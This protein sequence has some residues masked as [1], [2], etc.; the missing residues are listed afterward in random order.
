MSPPQRPQTHTP[1]PA[2]GLDLAAPLLLH[3]SLGD[4]I[5]TPE[6]E[7]RLGPAAWACCAAL[8]NALKLSVSPHHTVRRLQ[9][10]RGVRSWAVLKTGVTLSNLIRHSS[11]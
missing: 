8:A 1:L 3:G 10:V 9:G 7:S 2:P 11:T 6:D 5:G 4:Q